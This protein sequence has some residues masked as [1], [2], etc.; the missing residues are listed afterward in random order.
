[1]IYALSIFLS[2]LSAWAAYISHWPLIGELMITLVIFFAF[3]VA[4]KGLKTA[5]FALWVM[6]FIVIAIC[7]PGTKQQ[8][9]VQFSAY[10]FSTT[11]AY[12]SSFITIPKRKRDQ[13]VEQIKYAMQC[14]QGYMTD[15]FNH[16]LTSTIEK[17]SLK[18]YERARFT[19]NNIRN[20]ADPEMHL[21]FIIAAP[22]FSE[23][24]QQ[25]SYFFAR[26]FHLLVSIDRLEL[27]VLPTDVK[28]KFE[29]L[30]VGFQSLI[31]LLHQALSDHSDQPGSQ[32]VRWGKT[33]E[34]IQFALLETRNLLESKNL[35]VNHCLRIASFYYL[36]EKLSAE[37][38]QIS[39]LLAHQSFSQEL[40]S[41]KQ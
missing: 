30:N 15:V 16:I 12:F 38:Q 8:L 29:Y 24:M 41:W 20:L 27:S 37:F 13:P 10:L 23:S 11:A 9:W 21:K 22:K 39:Q 7:I 28:L 1:M 33:S 19:L 36:L 32:I 6:I 4:Y 31:Y 17:Q 35:S 40:Q 5:L 25:F 3:Y 34:I 18:S 14:M 26:I 2:I